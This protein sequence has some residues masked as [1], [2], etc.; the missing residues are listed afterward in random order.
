MHSCNILDIRVST[1]VVKDVFHQAQ[2]IREITLALSPIT[3]GAVLNMVTK[4]LN[5]TG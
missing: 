3:I 2:N 1:R 4:A 5:T